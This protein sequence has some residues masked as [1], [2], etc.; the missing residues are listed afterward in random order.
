MPQTHQRS[1][2]DAISGEKPIPGTSDGTDLFHHSA[3]A[4][5]VRDLFNELSLRTKKVLL[6]V[7]GHGILLKRI[8][9]PAFGNASMEMLDQALA[10]ELPNHIA[11]PLDQAAYDKVLMRQTEDANYLLMAW[12]RKEPLVSLISRLEA[13]GVEPVYVMPSSLVLASQL[14]NEDPSQRICGIHIDRDQ[15]DLVVVE[16]GQV[17]GGRSLSIRQLPNPTGLWRTLRQSLAAMPNPNQAE[18]GRIILFQT[19]PIAEIAGTP[20]TPDQMEQELNLPHCDVRE[21]TDKWA[22][23][24][25][26]CYLNRSGFSPNSSGGI[27]LNLITPILNQ[28]AHA[29]K[30]RQKQQIK[31]LIPFAAMLC[32]LAANVGM[33]DIVEST[34]SRVEALHQDRN[35]VKKKERRIKGL[36][37]KQEKF[38]KQVTALAW[39]ER[40]FRPLADRL[41][42]VAESIPNPVR[43]TEIKTLE[44]PRG[45]QARVDFD[46][47]ETFILTGLAKA[48]EEIDGFRI[49][50]ATHGDFHAVRQ[51]QTEQITV[52]G[53]KWLTFA[54]SLK[55]LVEL[56]AA[57]ET[58][59]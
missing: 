11:V 7:P 26:R 38:Q 44:A 39:G 16:D 46:A 10:H 31:R 36:R 8:Q 22:S 21:S 12:M 4:Q 50:L 34:R 29:K 24:L 35:V 56:P 59:G 17:L 20:I 1:R 42:Q 40:R 43:L 55:S 6:S 3:L 25:L 13:I 57:I 32:L 48:Q 33:W 19:T 30:Q 37:E 27:H 9:I 58:R 49:A 23:A 53:E 54:L 28:R 41:V 45:S 52:K 47:R 15:L 51:I 18:F 14:L 2:E 5:T